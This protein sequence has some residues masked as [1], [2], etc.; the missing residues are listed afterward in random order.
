MNCQFIQ[1]PFARV[2]PF[3]DTH[4]A[5]APR[6]LG[7]LESAKTIMRSSGNAGSIVR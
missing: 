1:W 2:M 4:L 6:I 7:G 3:T 5:A